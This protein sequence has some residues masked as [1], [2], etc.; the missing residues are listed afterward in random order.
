MSQKGQMVSWRN[1]V[2]MVNSCRICY[3]LS[4]YR[5]GI[6]PLINSFQPHLRYPDT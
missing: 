4:R 1:Y 3:F 6:L 2:I 5:A